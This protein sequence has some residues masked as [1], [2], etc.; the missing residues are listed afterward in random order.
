MRDRVLS[1][2]LRP[3]TYYFQNL[4]A[5]FGRRDFL[6]YLL[7]DPFWIDQVGCTVNSIVF[8]TEALF[9]TPNLIQITYLVVLIC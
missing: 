4:G 1:E 9:R 8:L 2:G 6:E 5:V 7:D 3:L